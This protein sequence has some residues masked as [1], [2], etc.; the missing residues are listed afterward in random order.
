MW[1][2][3]LVKNKNIGLSRI[4]DSRPWATIRV[5]DSRPWATIRVKDIIQG[6]QSLDGYGLRSSLG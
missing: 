3:I 6:W 5:K 1:N 4:K 2:L